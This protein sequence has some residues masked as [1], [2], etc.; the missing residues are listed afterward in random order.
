MAGGSSSVRDPSAA[1][2]RSWVRPNGGSPRRLAR[3]GVAIGTTALALLA[4]V[5]IDYWVDEVSAFPL[6]LAAVMVSSWYGGLGP[7]LLTIGLGLPVVTYLFVSPPYSLAV[8]TLTGVERLTVSLLVA[9]LINWLNT[10]RRRA[11][12]RVQ[13]QAERRRLVTELACELAGTSLDLRSILQTAAIRTAEVAGDGCVLRLVPEGG[14]QLDP[15]AVHHRDPSTATRLRRLL[16]DAPEA[17][18]GAFARQVAATAEPHRSSDSD[19]DHP[20]VAGMAATAAVPVA[21]I[22]V[23]PLAIHDRVLGTLT[24]WHQ[25][26]REPYLRDDELFLQELA[27]CIALAVDNGR[28]YRAAREAEVRYRSLFDGSADAILVADRD[29]GV[30]DVNRAARDLLGEGQH[31]LRRIAPEALAAAV[32]VNARAETTGEDV[33]GGWRGEIEVRRPD[34]TLLPMDVSV[35]PVALPSRCVLLATLRDISERRRLQEAQREFI[36]SLSHDL[37]TPLTAIRTG[38]VLLLESAA[39]RLLS[40]E[41]ELLRHAKANS[42]RLGTM[43]R[44]LLALNQLEAGTFALDRKPLDLRV[45]V[46]GALAATTAPIREKQQLLDVDVPTALPVAGDKDRLEQVVCNLLENAHHHTPEGTKIAV[47]G[48]ATDESVRLTVSDNGPGIPEDELE[49]A[50]R[51][52]HRLRAGGPGSG[53]GLAIARRLAEAH[54]GRLVAENR[55]GGGALFHLTFPRDDPGGSA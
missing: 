33:D 15:V 17:F 13:V 30:L 28:L 41:R 4:A 53:L 19:H 37:R 18:D 47:V 34:G 5:A 6:L 52:F 32:P 24:V 20:S 2:G 43:I 9:L 45:V 10:R 29:G 48:R 12:A 23:M 54:G 31:D 21:S 14:N 46:E 42:E 1:S 27:I 22:V 25:E 26:F 11:E 3:Y 8:A 35:S 50:F 39:D 55:P 7:G 51:Q 44:D 36:L 38:V 40:S 16:A 49:A